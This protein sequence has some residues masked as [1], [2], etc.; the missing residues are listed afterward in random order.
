MHSFVNP[1]NRREAVQRLT[2]LL[3]GVLSIPLA[4][5]L[6][7][8]IINPGASV[9][10]DDETEGLLAEVADTIIP[11]TDTPGAKSAGAQEFILRVMRDCYLYEDQRDF[12]AGLAGLNAAAKARGKDFVQLEPAGRAEVLK[13]Y[14]EK[15]K[16]F[17]KTMR[18]LTVV[19]YFTSEIG[20]T[21]ALEYLPIPGRF[22][23]DVAMKPGQKT[24]AL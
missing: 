7:G 20:A 2:V 18:Q 4:A 11:A 8:E 12:Y 6:R 23:G 21:K 13:A 5:A 17:F 3:G 10:V 15:N 1:L 14:A 16:A 22:E 24:W 19:G 9:P